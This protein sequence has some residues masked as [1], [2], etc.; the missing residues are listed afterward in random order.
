MLKPLGRLLGGGVTA[1]VL[2][3]G[4]LAG[5]PVAH[6]DNDTDPLCY[7]TP[8]AADPP[9]NGPSASY[10]YD[11]R[12][13]FGSSI[14]IPRGLLDNRY[15]PQGMAAWANWNG[16]G[17]DILLIS[18]Y[19]DGDGNKEPDGNSAIFG[20]V[21]SGSRAGTGLGRMLISNGHVGGIAVYKGFAY[22][23][24]EQNIRGY[25]LSDVRDA[26]AGA[27]NGTVYGPL[28][29]RATSYVVG[30]M[31]SGDGHLWAGDFSTTNSTHL[32]GYVQTSASLG[33][34]EYRSATQSYAPKKT[35]GVVVTADHV[36]FST[37]YGRGDRGNLWVMRRNQQSLTDA[38]SYCFRTPS[39]N[40]GI[41]RIN[42]RVYLNFE[43]AAYTYT[44]DAGDRPRNSV[45]RIHTATT[46]ELTAL[47]GSSD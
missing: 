46:A 7:T 18:A 38:N 14:D 6:A 13:D 37:S 21:A 44:K 28:T 8:R 15:V 33:T 17:E 26:L 34:I 29:Q 19:H 32:N 2:I 36:L 30:F 23:G 41:T 27:D 25:R 1:A 47:Y 31:G 40:Q 3:A 16:T 39:M 22:V 43:S 20:V 11:T 5:A 35:Q 4:Q 45:K 12:F 42:G 10:V 9:Y 24:S